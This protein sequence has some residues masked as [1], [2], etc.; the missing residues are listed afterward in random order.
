M[1]ATTALREVSTTTVLCSIDDLIYNAGVCALISGP[2]GEE[3]VA[4]FYLPSQQP[5]I[6]A[7]SN[8]DPIGKANVM[9]RGILGSLDDTLVVASPLYKQH[10]SLESGACLEDPTV[11]LKTYDVDLIDNKV[12]LSNPVSTNVTPPQNSPDSAA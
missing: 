6:Y 3:Q 5:Q 9:S 7:L 8:W 11:S 12:V 2:H 1:N 4:L 10:F